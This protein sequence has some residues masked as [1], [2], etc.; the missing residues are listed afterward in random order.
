M[1]TTTRRKV[2]RVTREVTPLESAVL[3][4]ARRI[5]ALDP[6]R[7]ASELCGG[8]IPDPPTGNGP[9]F[10]YDAYCVVARHI[11]GRMHNDDRL[12][13]DRY[14]RYWLP[15]DPSNPENEEDER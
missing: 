6:S 5:G 15:D 12:D 11:L 14:G 7:L 2:A 9:V 4:V 3:A 10:V 8:V 1:S 13:Q